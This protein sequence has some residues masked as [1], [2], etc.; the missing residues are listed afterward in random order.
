VTADQPTTNPL[1]AYLASVG[2]EA[3]L[4]RTEREVPTVDLAAAALGVAPAAIVKSIV[5][6]HKQDATRVCL[7]IVSG[8]ARV[9]RQKVSDAFGLRQLRLA[10]PDTVLQVTGYRA[11][12]VPPVCHLQP[13][14]VALDRRVFE[15]RVV[16]G[17]GGDEW[18]MLRIAPHDIQRLTGAVVADL[19]EE[20]EPR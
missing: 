13:I 11:G 1:P 18:H 8:D 7:A 2:V 3:T 10:S 12:G 17:G 5:F 9:S 15:H 19:I 6:E 16:F 20:A 14:P 4:V